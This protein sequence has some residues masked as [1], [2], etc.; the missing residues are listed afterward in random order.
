MEFEKSIP[1]K[2]WSPD[3]FVGRFGGIDYK[4]AAGGTYNV[5]ASQASHF[6]KQLSVRE[7][8]ARGYEGNMTR[9]E[10]LS[11]Q[12]MAEYMGRCFP[13]TKPG[14]VESS[15]GSFDRIDEVK[16]EAAKDATGIKD[17]NTTK[18][19]E[20]PDDEDNADDEKNNAGA[21]KFKS[22]PK[23]LKTK[24]ADYQ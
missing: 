16:D 7:L 2:N 11:D 1:F 20:V 9:G 14:D 24:D 5:P 21:P 4:F 19:R 18:E 15:T 3:E 22:A 17:A 6:A 12:D 13:S 8:H 10:M 23:K